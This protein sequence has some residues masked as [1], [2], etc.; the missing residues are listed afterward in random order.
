MLSLDEI[1]D[2]LKDKRLYA[3][4]KGA[5]VCYPTLRKIT[6]RTTE[7]F[8]LKTIKKISDYLEQ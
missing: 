7:N 6:D 2:R 5:G 8:Q 4:A 1:R 3:V